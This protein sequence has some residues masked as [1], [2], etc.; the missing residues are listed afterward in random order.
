[1]IEVTVTADEL[2]ARQ[3]SPLSIRFANA[4]QGSCF[5]L[6]FKLKL[7]A[8]MLLMGGSDQVE[9]PVLAPGR[10]HTHAVIVQA[11]LPG[12]FVLTSSN[13]SYRDKLDLPVRVTDFRAILAVR[14][15]PAAP[16]RKPAGRLAV[17]YV[18]GELDLDGWDVLRINVTNHTGVPVDTLTVAAE[19]PSVGG[20]RSADPPT[21]LGAGA[22]A[23][24]SL[25]VHLTQG[26]RHVPVTLRTTYRHPSG[27]LRT[28]EDHITVVVRRAAPQP[29]VRSPQVE[30]ADVEQAAGQTV[31]YLAASPRDLPPLRPDLEMRKVEEK[32]RLSR[33]RH[34]YR[35]KSCVAVRFDDLS[36][37]LV[38]YE[39]Q[40]IH[41]AG[42][43]DKDGSLRVEDELGDSEIITPEGLAA[44]FGQ[45]RATVRCVVLNAC[46]SARLAEALAAQIEYVIGMRYPIGDEAAIEFS[47]GFYLGLFAGWPVPEAFKRGRSYLLARPRLSAQHLTP[48]IFPPV[49]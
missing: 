27:G 43:G 17:A 20:G 16:A 1:M 4:G 40:V 48:Q 26:G 3:R 45:H 46:Y 29:G 25:P 36:Q 49:D 23:R 5:N 33:L 44:L 22:S 34:R 21:S 10:T 11:T 7:P 37:A 47:V 12:Q 18:G 8:G 24:L 31:L 13:F 19:G 32:L 41:F 35:I 39:P 38:D 9:L 28:Q 2:V 30:Q 6:V 14:P 15:P 42:Y